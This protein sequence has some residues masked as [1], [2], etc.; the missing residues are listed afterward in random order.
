MIGYLA[1][2]KGAGGMTPVTSE[3]GEGSTGIPIDMQRRAQETT[4]R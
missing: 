4:D 2:G 3:S 1:S